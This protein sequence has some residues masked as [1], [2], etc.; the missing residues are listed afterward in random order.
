MKSHFSQPDFFSCHFL[1][2]LSLNIFQQ[3]VRVLLVAIS[4]ITGMGGM[5]PLHTFVAAWRIC[6]EEE[7]ISYLILISS[8]PPKSKLSLGMK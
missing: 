7:I 6:V 5:L 8:G 4:P 2:L 1:I 3:S